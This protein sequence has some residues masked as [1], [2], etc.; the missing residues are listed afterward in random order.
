VFQALAAIDA[1][2]GQFCQPRSIRDAALDRGADDFVFADG[3]HA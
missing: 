3:P 1:D 2:D